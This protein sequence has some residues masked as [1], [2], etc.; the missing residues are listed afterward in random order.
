M[1]KRKLNLNELRVNSFVT[2][3]DDVNQ[4]T[5]KGG[6]INSCV[7]SCGTYT[8]MTIPASPLCIYTEQS[9]GIICGGNYTIMM[10]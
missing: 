10:Q 3:N 6:V 8:T 2:S 1:K 5:V 9:C 7:P 4:E